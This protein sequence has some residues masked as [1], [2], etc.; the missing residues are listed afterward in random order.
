MPRLKRLAAIGFLAL[1]VASPETGLAAVWRV[2]GESMAP[3]LED[4]AMV[5]V[6]QVGPTIAG[7]RRGDV[8]ILEPPGSEG[9]Y[10]MSTMIK[11][12]V[13]L[14]GERVRVVGPR[15]SIDGRWLDEPYVAAISPGAVGVVDVVVGPDSVFVMGDHRG[16]SFDSTSFGAVPVSQLHGRVAFIIGWGRLGVPAHS[17]I[18][19]T[20]AAE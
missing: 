9:R 16:E 20:F 11:R 12:V 8:V 1:L 3:E 13:G 15:V 17:P 7:Y 4:G 10:P 18:P 5:V 14:P 19:G 6:D 2:Q